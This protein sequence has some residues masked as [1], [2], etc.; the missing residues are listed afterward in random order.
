M[1]GVGNE[2]SASSRS[3]ESKKAPTRMKARVKS[4]IIPRIAIDI[5][6][7]DVEIR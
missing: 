3:A 7:D 5:E 4:R 1:R 2:G 6:G